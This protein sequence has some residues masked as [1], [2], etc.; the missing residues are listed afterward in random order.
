M[1]IYDIYNICILKYF[2]SS[3]A[4][5]EILNTFFISIIILFFHLYYL[6]IYLYKFSLLC[7]KVKK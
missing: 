1:A 7:L 3:D 5:T 4:M 6:F 2:S